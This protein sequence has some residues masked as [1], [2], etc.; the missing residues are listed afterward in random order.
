MVCADD[1]VNLEYD[2]NP[3]RRLDLAN[4]K[5]DRLVLHPSMTRLWPGLFLVGRP[6]VTDGMCLEGV[7]QCDFG[8]E[9]FYA[10]GRFLGRQVRLV[11]LW[12]VG[13]LSQAL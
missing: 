11:L 10:A 13:V 12:L 5:F 7:S 3:N 8:F 9:R 6:G 2:P 1:W 4:V